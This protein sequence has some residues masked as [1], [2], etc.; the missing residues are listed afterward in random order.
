MLLL[1]NTTK[2]MNF[3]ASVLPD[4]ETAD[5]SLLKTAQKLA[6]RVSKMTPRQLAELM[7][8]S[9]K[10]AA[11]THEKLSL[12]GKPDQSKVPALFGFTGLFFKHLDAYSLS[13]NQLSFVRANVRILSGLYGLL[14]PFD[15]IEVYRLEM[16]YKLAE[17][18]F[19]NLAQFWKETLTAKLN[20]ELVPGEPIFSVASQE[21]MKALD[22][23]KLDHPVIMPVFKEKRPDGSY[24]NAVVHAKKARGAIIRY[25][26]E[27]KAKKPKDLMGFSAQGWAAANPPP[28]NGSWL[29]TRPVN[30]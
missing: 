7:S 15:L 6:G 4:M 3:S 24:K 26:I 29:F 14:E 17:G 28:D 21:Y 8:L 10:L 5:P 20:N 25:A 19:S 1:L 12:W 2:T 16:G 23:K 9:D 13:K 22:I 27:N 30:R 11:G 18:G